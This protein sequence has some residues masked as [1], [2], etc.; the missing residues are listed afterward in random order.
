MAASAVGADEHRMSLIEHLIELRRRFFI[1]AL[2]IVAVSIAA[3]VFY[4]HV[5]LFLV[6]YYRDATHD[7]SKNFAVFGALEGFATRLRLS[8]YIGLFG[9][10]PIW[11]W[12][13]WRFITPGLNPNEK[14]YAIPF[15]VSSVLLFVGG[16]AMALYTLPA[17]LDFLVANAG[18]Y[19]EPFYNLDKFVGLVTLIIVAFGFAFL[20]PVVI[21]FLELV[22]ILQWKTLLK[23]WRYAIVIIF[24]I[25]AVI[26]PSQD[27]YTLVGMAGPMCIF[28]FASI[29]IGWLAKR[30][31]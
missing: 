12:Q 21:V 7:T 6:N 19:A 15:V 8:S 2:A 16:A 3:Y 13:L 27:P 28:Y 31:K 4:D 11:L 1:S 30:N 29:G 17:G 10:S 5:Q 23:G 26:T 20:F 25:A 22:N 9:S 18:K 24:I 14:K